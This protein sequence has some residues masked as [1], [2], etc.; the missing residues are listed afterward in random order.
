VSLSS[1]N[2]FKDANKFIPG[3]VNSPVRAFSSVGG[4]PIFIKSAKGAYVYSEDG[5]KYLDFVGSWGPMILGHAHPDVIN[6]VISAAKSGLSFGAPT[7]IETE[8]ARLICE[9]YPSIDMVR[10]VSSGTEA[11]MSA[12][13][14]ARGFTKCDKII[15]FTGCYHG[16]SDSLLVQAGSGAL[17]LGKPSSAGVPSDIT[18]NT[19]SLDYNNCEQVTNVCEQIGAEIAC[20]IV[21]P[22]AGNMSCIPAKK[23]FLQTLRELC[24]K[25]KIV[26]I[27]DE[28]MSGFRVSLGGAQQVYN[29]M[30]DLTTLGKIVGGGMSVGSFGGRGDI[31]QHIAPTGDVYQA[32]TLSGNPLAMSAGLTTLKILQHDSE[33]IYTDLNN[34]TSYLLQKLQNKADKHNIDFSTNQ[35]GA[36]FGLFFSKDK[37]IDTFE[38]VNNC[39]QDRFNSFFNFMIENKIYF[40]PSSFE[41]GFLS[42]AHTIDD[43]DKV[44][45]VADKFFK[46]L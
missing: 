2:L 18:K 22:V 3:G 24:D 20:I 32:G 43:C 39:Q 26:L 40:A 12:I 11:V 34:K 28:V 23:E 31:M 4:K 42:T 21:E 45:G 14:L 15:K 1:S 9:I 16:H 37:N 17:T 38:K 8:L 6:A 46:T 13:R 19:L 44:I 7:K 36:M 30:P 29:I 33:K 10:M 41:A 27:F 35:A 5:N 25:Y